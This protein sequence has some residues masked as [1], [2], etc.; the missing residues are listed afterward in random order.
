MD[1]FRNG[2]LQLSICDIQD[3]YQNEAFEDE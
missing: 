1:N 3:N 2:N